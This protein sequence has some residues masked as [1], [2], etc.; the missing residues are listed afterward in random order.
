MVA[1]GEW[2][3]GFQKEGPAES[4]PVVGG[5]CFQDHCTTLVQGHMAGGLSVLVT[6]STKEE[7]H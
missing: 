7:F 5:R 4:G 3:E 6:E 1:K 2:M